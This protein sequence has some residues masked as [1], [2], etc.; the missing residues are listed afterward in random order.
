MK[1]IALFSTLALSVGLIGCASNGGG[2]ASAN[3]DASTYMTKSFKD[4][5]ANDFQAKGSAGLDR[6][7]QTEAQHECS[8]Y[9]YLGKPIPK[10]IASRIEKDHYSKVVYP[11]DGQ[12]FGDWKEGLKIAESG[13]GMT[14]NDKPGTP[15]G[16]NC[17]NCHAL[18]PNNPSQGNLGP[19]LVGYG[20]TRGN[21][22]EV[23][24][25]TWARI[26]DS[27]AFNACSQ[28]PPLGANHVLTQQQMK[29]IMA[30]LFDPQSPVNK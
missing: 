10:E 17:I 11:A 15:N 12:Y 24:K 30:L 16:G 29:D 1:K 4:I 13:K 28:M 5:I 27:T 2:M 14:W 7:V 25:Y 8:K 6:M 23:V 20:K 21:S 22:M 26:Y 18:L 19:S 9:D 3:E